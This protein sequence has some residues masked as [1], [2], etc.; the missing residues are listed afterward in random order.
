METLNE[1]YRNNIIRS[2]H[3]YHL[4]QL[5]RIKQWCKNVSYLGFH[6]LVISRLSTTLRLLSALPLLISST[7][8]IIN[9]LIT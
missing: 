9:D 7:V 6:V 5:M 1:G 3:F 4:I 8:Y 2:N